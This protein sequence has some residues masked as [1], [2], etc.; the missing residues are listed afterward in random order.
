MTER[1]YDQLEE[2]ALASKDV[3]IL[4]VDDHPDVREFVIEA[5]L[6]PSGYQ[7]LT[8]VDG[9]AALEIAL[10]ER[11]D[12]ILLDYELPH[13]SGIE[14]LE[15]LNEQDVHIPVILITSYGSES[16]AVEVF[17]LGVRDYVPK[18]FS[19]DEITHSIER[20]LESTSMEKERDLIMQRLKETNAELARH[21]RELDTLYHVGKSVTTLRER[22]QVMERIVDA[23][24]YLSGAQDGMLVLVD[25]KTGE[26]SISVNRMQ[27]GT[28]YISPDTSVN[29]ITHTQGLMMALPLRVGEKTLGTLMVSNKR[30]R[31]PLDRH[32]Q[33]LLRM[34]ADYAA[35]AIENSRLLTELDA[36]REQEKQELRS[37]FEHYV[38]PPVVE[39]LLEQPQSVRPGGQRQTISVLFADLRGF[40]TF[41]AQSSP[42]ALISVLNHHIAVA[43]EAILL[44]EGTLDKFMGDEVMAFFNAPLPQ[45]DYALHAVQAALRILEATKKVHQKFPPHQQLDFGVGIATGEAIVGNV[46]TH[47]MVNYTVVGNTVNK[48]HTLQELAPA[49][50]ILLCHQTYELLQQRVRVRELPPIHFK[51]QR[52]SEPLYELL[53]LIDPPQGG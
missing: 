31:R 32:D 18:P 7:Y 46:G 23:A 24:L 44:E 53:A 38:A 27:Q 5:I 21:L 13:M 12:L 42:E 17:R 35:I 52:V 33:R 40:T 6:K 16:I 36:Q 11:P 29:L 48:A 22:D 10:E 47:G 37:L 51:G 49:G 14:V 20:V 19:I 9:R 4:L 2:I 39:R 26:P 45:E 15:A 34:L 28:D 50:K 43:A 1:L 41:S 30:N 25:P 8:A 3:R